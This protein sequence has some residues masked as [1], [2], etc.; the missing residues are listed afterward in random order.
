MKI[1]QEKLK[2]LKTSLEQKNKDL[3]HVASLVNH[4]LQAPINR[5]L[6]FVEILKEGSDPKEQNFSISAIE[7]SAFEMRAI[8]RHL[9]SI[10]KESQKN[11]DFGENKL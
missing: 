2:I 11:L 10:A 1:A 4:D 7:T 6:G 9:L 8:A 5:I 3:E